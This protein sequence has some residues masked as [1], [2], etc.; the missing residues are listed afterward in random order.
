MFVC[1]QFDRPEEKIAEVTAALSSTVGEQCL[2][3]FPQDY[4]SDAE[5]ACITDDETAVL[6]RAQLTGNDCERL[7]SHIEMWV[8][9][10]SASFA[11]MNNRLSVDANCI[12]EIESLQATLSCSETD[13]S[14]ESSSEGQSNVLII[15]AAAGGVIGVIIIGIIVVAAVILCTRTL[16]R[17]R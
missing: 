11:V 12:L 15:G 6:F 3:S 2:C 10:G 4:I 14:S 13:P 8:E 17:Q 9:S 7:L 5:F 1:H 16:K